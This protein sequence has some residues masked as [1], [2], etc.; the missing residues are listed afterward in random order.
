MI[1]VVLDGTESETASPTQVP[2]P[3]LAIE[4][5]CDSATVLNL[6]LQGALEWLQQTS[7]TVPAPASQHSMPRRKLLSAALGALPIQVSHSSSPPT[8]SKTLDAAS[9]SPV[10]SLN[11]TRAS[12]T[13]LPDEVL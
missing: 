6:H 5:L 1:E 10:C 2:P 13:S 3:F 7:P 4:S 11:P 9:I 12:P 8:V